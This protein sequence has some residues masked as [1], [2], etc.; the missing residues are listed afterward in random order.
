[1]KIG[2]CSS[3]THT[4][5]HTHTHTVREGKGLT[6]PF[7]RQHRKLALDYCFSVL[8]PLKPDEGRMS[9]VLRGSNTYNKYDSC[10]IN[11]IAPGRLAKDYDSLMGSFP[12]TTCLQL[13]TSL[14]SF[15]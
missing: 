8:F 1:M 13:G 4:H 7:L 10:L 3:S 11:C 2:P 6:Q 5:T 12:D 9:A 15:S 14:A